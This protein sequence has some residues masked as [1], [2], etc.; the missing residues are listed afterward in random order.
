MT[1]YYKKAKKNGA[2]TLIC[3]S[4]LDAPQIQ[5]L[6]EKRHGNAR[7]EPTNKPIDSELSPQ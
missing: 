6:L 7:K 4:Q 5:C 2:R 3:E 1:S